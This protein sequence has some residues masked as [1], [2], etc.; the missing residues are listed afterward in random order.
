[1]AE[2]NVTAPPAGTARFR[3]RDVLVPAGIVGIVFLMIIPVPPFLLD[4]FLSLSMTV[5]IVVLLVSV[6]MV[7][8]LEFSVFPSVLLTTTLYRLSLN[9]A[10]SRLILLR[11]SEGADAAGAVIKAFGQFVVGGNYAVGVVV[12]LILVIINFVVIT[13]GAGRIAEVAARFSLD[14]MPGKQMSIDADL[15]AGFID[16]QEARR[17]RRQIEMEADFC[18]AMDGASKFI[19]GEAVAGIV[20]TCI[21][22]LGGFF[23]GVFQLGLDIRT[24]AET[25]TI[26][27]VGDGLIAQIPAL[28]VSTAAGIIVARAA[29]DSDLGEDL[30]KQLIMRPKALATASVI[31][32]GLGLVPGLPHVAFFLLAG[33]S[34]AAAY[35][36][37]AGIAGAEAPTAEPLPE[38]SAEERLD[39]VLAM[40]ILELEIGYGLIP[41]VDPDQGG[42]LLERVR[43]VRRQTA[44]ERGFIIPSVHIR[45]NLEI[46]PQEYLIR[47]KGVEIARG[48]VRPGSLLALNP[49]HVSADIPG[50]PAQEPA[51]GLPAK[52]IE[53]RDRE[54]ARMSGFTVVDPTT[55]I[56]THLTEL[57]KRHSH[58]IITRQDVQKLLDGLKESYP[59]VVEET[60]PALLP[61]GTVL[62]VLQNLLREQVSIKDLLTILETMGNVGHQVKDPELL[63]EY[64]RQSLSRSITQ[65]YKTAENRL[66]VVSL[67]KP[68]EDLLEG[69]I[70]RT[71]MG[72]YL[73][74]E[75]GMARMILQRITDGVRKCAESGCEPVV[76]CNP[77]VRSSLK[78]LTE[79]SIP[80]LTV[81]SFQEVAPSVKIHSLGTVG[82]S[83]AN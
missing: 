46:K 77:V 80:E 75:P 30:N 16:E 36:T 67:E 83:Y 56:A 3:P 53:E 76:L 79:R 40:D 39:K 47:I 48:E 70:Q 34:G 45:D 17:R 22:I 71:D 12:F 58:E 42:D 29:A 31:L 2:T 8:P 15:N 4:I 78:H 13:K 69:A 52:W 57:I 66:Y 6:Y 73:A 23:I 26:L 54:T 65:Q 43:A 19:R 37:R 68:L 51:F 44:Q 55:V 32:A 14:A 64:V 18:G 41:L 1:M 59:K 33:L 7:R 24:A 82:L 63:T 27:T 81:L 72:S 74:L 38:P 11:G 50:I 25:Y 28:L 20:I 61:L 60:V 10:S 21:N 9:V 35:L 49:G 62:R 5:A